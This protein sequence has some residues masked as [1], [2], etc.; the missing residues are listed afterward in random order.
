MIRRLARLKHPAQK[1]VRILRDSD[2]GTSLAREQR[3]ATIV[4]FAF[5]APLMCVTLLGFLDLG[6]RAYVT[7]VIQGALRD[8]AR[9]A[10]VGG[11]T[12]SQIDDEVKIR[13]K[14]FSKKA[15]ITINKYSYADFGDVKMPEKISQDTAPLGAYNVGDCYE[16]SNGNGQYDLDK[17]KAGLG[18]ADDIVY[19]EVVMSFPRLVP[20]GKFLGF[21]NTQTI[22]ASTVLQNQPFAVRSTSVA[23]RCT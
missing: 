8:A 20:L 7:S 15:T 22:K 19:Y 6:Y 14:D 1:S 9:M 4:E 18:G 11:K 5:I 17:G 16:D 10:T 21:S 23:V 13:L 12:G 3:G 2:A